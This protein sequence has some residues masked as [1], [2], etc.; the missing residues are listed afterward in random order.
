MAKLDGN[1]VVDR[2]K[3]A[4]PIRARDIFSTVKIA[5]LATISWTIPERRWPFIAQALARVVTRLKTRRRRTQR[6][7]LMFND[8]FESSALDHMGTRF[9]AHSYLA[10]MQGFREYWPGGWRPEIQVVGAENI[11]AAL[12]QGHGVLLW[13]AGFAY[14][15]LVTK[16]GLHEAGYRV[17][18]LSRPSHNISRTRFGIRV[19][20]PVWTRIEDRYLAE[21]VVIR[22]DDAG[23]AL[24]VLR[25]RLEENRIVSI[26]VG[27]QA[28]RTAEVDLLSTKLRPATG[29]LHLAQTTK[30]VLLPVFTVMRETGAMVVNVE[31]P[32]IG[33]GD[34]QEEPYESVCQCYARRLERFV[35]QYPDQWNQVWGL[36]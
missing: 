23:S 27:A 4:S 15:N 34:D 17:S 32:L 14:N 35:L 9:L 25:A 31:G 29:P 11:E 3:T 24:A 5:L 30:A 1:G 19:L 28:R 18:H 10:R 6:R 26:T 36:E 12:V 13:I 20:N 22:D 2:A 21:R 16:K 33:G 7:R 8:R